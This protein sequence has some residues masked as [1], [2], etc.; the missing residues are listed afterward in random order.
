MLSEII[1]ERYFCRVEFYSKAGKPKAAGYI[2]AMEKM[3]TDRDTTFSVG[4][5]LFTDIWG[6]SNAGIK[7]IMVKRIASH[8]EIQIHLKRIPETLITVIY[9]LLYKKR[10][11][12]D[13]L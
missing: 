11:E 4:D 8:E 12:K 3:G 9:R 7:S 10:S 5:Q 2:K 6:A 1:I 13:L